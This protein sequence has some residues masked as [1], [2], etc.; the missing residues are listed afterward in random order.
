[1]KIAFHTNL[2]GDVERLSNVMEP[3]IDA[4][5]FERK[6]EEK[7]FTEAELDAFTG[8]YLVM[9]VQKL[10]VSRK[11]G[12]LQITV[13]GQPTYTLEYYKGLEFKLQ[14]L[15]GY[16]TLFQKNSSGEVTGLM[17]IQPNGQFKGEKVD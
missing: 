4:I 12:Q 8:Q 10:T 16:S 11:D 13:P 7:A 5:Y 14:G 2:D 17:M 15:K 6:A 9:G 3:S 1:M